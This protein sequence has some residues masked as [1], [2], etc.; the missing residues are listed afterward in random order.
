MPDRNP[1]G[2]ILEQCTGKINAK[3]GDKIEN[4]KY[5]PRSHRDNFGESLESQSWFFFGAIGF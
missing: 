1:T 3:G 4:L 5:Y 2:M